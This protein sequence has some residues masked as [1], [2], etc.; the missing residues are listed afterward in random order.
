MLVDPDGLTRYA[1]EY[2]SWKGRD[3]KPKKP[4]SFPPSK[5]PNVEEEVEKGI[6]KRLDKEF[7]KNF[8]EE[9]VDDKLG[10]MLSTQEKAGK[11]MEKSIEENRLIGDWIYANLNELGEK[12]EAVKKEKNRE[13]RLKIVKELFGKKAE[14]QDQVLIFDV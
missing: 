11:E 10:R 7:A 12:F 13:K 8:K 14:I 4:Y 6:S 9:I 1:L 5:E 2:R 3:I